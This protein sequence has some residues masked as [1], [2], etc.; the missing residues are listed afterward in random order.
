MALSVFGQDENG[1]SSSV[2]Q[3]QPTLEFSIDFLKQRADSLYDQ[4]LYSESVTL[5]EDIKQKVQEDG[6][7]EELSEINYDLGYNH[8]FLNNYAKAIQAFSEHLILNPSIDTHKKINIFNKMA[9][10][11]SLLGDMEQAYAYQLKNLEL[12]ESLEDS[13]KIAQANYEI[14]SVL[15]SLENYENA[16]NSYQKAFEINK[17][18]DDPHTLYSCLAAIGCVYN[19]IGDL[20]SAI[21]YNNKSLQL[22]YELDYQTG[23]AY[24]YQNLA[25]DFSSI[26]DYDNAILYCEKS[27]EIKYKTNDQWGIC[28]T[29][30]T[31]GEIYIK[32]NELE[33]AE[34]HLK[35][36]LGI[37]KQLDS[38]IRFAE[39]YKLSSELNEKKGNYK[40]SN[41][42][43]QKYIVVKEQIINEATLMKMES[44]KVHYEISKKD[45]EIGSLKKGKELQSIKMKAV[46]YILALM[47]I[48]SLITGYSYI[49]IKRSNKLLA[50]KNVIIEEQ[51]IA[52]ER[53]NQELENFAYV[54]SHDMREPIR[55]IRSFSGLLNNRYG[56]VIGEKGLEFIHFI[57]DASKRMDIMLTDLLEYSRANTRNKDKE[58]ID[59]SNA[60]T[61]AMANLN[62][63][64]E[65]ENVEL[66]AT[67][68]P[69]VEANQIQMVR[70]FQN[71][72]ANAIK[73]NK[74][75]KKIISVDFKKNDSAYIISV[76]DNG[77]GID[78]EYWEQ[79]FEIFRRLHT[80]VEYE[81]SGIGLAT[82]KK[83]VERHKGKIWIDSKPD[84]GTTV[85]FTLPFSQN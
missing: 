14:G 15:F 62:K 67:D 85:L 20:D 1:N 30:R 65:E 47:L 8:F 76:K 83:I 34:R 63:I 57:D 54:A 38:K 50:A 10:S 75:A 39:I 79:V 41:D 7:E 35:I 60:L 68:L 58:P 5:Y 29:E 13:E 40:R 42:Y 3:F 36:A 2:Y 37:A 61:L 19:R 77:I 17:S 45:W 26:E 73:Y 53:S 25:T 55:T 44:S 46:L 21:L 66:N 6:M 18:L 59:L 69:K 82:C 23:K 56:G 32:K 72:I 78:S 31:L 27:L 43:L 48:F 49:R 28:G 84:E 71:L 64:I 22:A 52:L 33:E 81:G 12:S 80:N 74:N 4:E 24:A 11:A 51:N 70:L 9:K 16:L